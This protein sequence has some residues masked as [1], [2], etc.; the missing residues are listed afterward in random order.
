VNGQGDGENEMQRPRWGARAGAASQAPLRRE[1][2]GQRQK[3]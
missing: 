2:P 3:I 1:R